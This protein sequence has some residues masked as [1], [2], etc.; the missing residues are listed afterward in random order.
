MSL[1]EVIPFSGRAK[2][3]EV[4]GNIFLAALGSLLT[5]V[6]FSRSRQTFNRCALPHGS[7]SSLS[8]SPSSWSWRLSGTRQLP[9][10]ERHAR[11]GKDGFEV[12]AWR[13]DWWHAIALD[14]GFGR[15]RSC[16]LCVG[17]PCWQHLVPRRVDSRDS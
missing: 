11:D 14:W 2:W 5:W 8:A 1:P 12:H 7:R 13:G 3:G 9:T 4:A 15:S 10:V 17:V 6:A 16:D